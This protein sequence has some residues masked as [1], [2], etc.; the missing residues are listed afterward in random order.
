[1][2]SLLTAVTLWPSTVGLL[3]LFNFMHRES[4]RRVLLYDCLLLSLINSAELH[5]CWCMGWGSGSLLLICFVFYL[6]CFVVLL[7]MEWGLE[8]CT[9][10]LGA[11]CSLLCFLL[12]L[13]S[14]PHCWLNLSH[15]EHVLFMNILIQTFFFL[16]DTCVFIFLE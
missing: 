11:K 5:S 1:M 7:G 10:V 6:F 8:H 2:L 12:L 16:V 15:D 14:I 4:S 13:D 3:C 9:L